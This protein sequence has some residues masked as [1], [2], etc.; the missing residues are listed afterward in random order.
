MFEFKNFDLLTDGE[1]DLIIEE[2]AP[3]NKEKGYVPAYKYKI[4]QHN[5]SQ[6]IGEIDI[7]IGNNKNTYYGGNVGYSIDEAFR[8]N[9]YAS[10]A[11]K[12]IKQVAIGHDMEKIIITCNPDNL[13]SRRTCEKIGIALKEIVNLPEDNEM[14]LEGETQK[15]VFEWVL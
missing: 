10:K 13:P 9:S 6:N 3:E 12:L 15:C 4:R 2:M 7:R 8:G 14:Y 11:C 1:L 5:S